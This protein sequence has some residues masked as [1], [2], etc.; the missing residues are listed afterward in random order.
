M[1]KHSLSQAKL[2]YDVTRGVQIDGP[3]FYS[4]ACRL[5]TISAIP[6]IHWLLLSRRQI[7]KLR[8][9][10]LSVCLLM[11]FCGIG[12]SGQGWDLRTSLWE[13][14]MCFQTKLTLAI[15]FKQAN[16][17]SSAPA[18][19]HLRMCLEL[20]SCLGNSCSLEEHV[21]SIQ[22]GGSWETS[23]SNN[24]R[25]VVCNISWRSAHSSTF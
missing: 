12:D 9:I 3:S 8:R 21:G 24:G 15:N 22:T 13:L 7:V 11:V 19:H 4:N 14:S 25:E 6:Q 2:I 18:V 20:G 17:E 23:R 1:W 16:A 10:M 5:S